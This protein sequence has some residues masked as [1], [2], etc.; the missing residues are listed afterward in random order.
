MLR[1]RTSGAIPSWHG[2]GQLHPYLV[3]VLFLDGADQELPPLV[4][5]EALTLQRF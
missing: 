5:A 4:Q 1:L 2:Q 3:P